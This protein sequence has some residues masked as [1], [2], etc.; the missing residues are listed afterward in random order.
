MFLKTSYESVSWYIVNANDKK[1][2][3][4]NVIK[5]FLS[6]MEYKRKND[7]LLVYDN[8]KFLT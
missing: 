2:A 5:H 1:D 7:E 6:N 8:E 4:I 3:R